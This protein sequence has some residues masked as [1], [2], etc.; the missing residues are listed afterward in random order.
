VLE[1]TKTSRVGWG[2]LFL[3]RPLQGA[4][5]KNLPFDS[6][7]TSFAETEGSYFENSNMITNIN[8]KR[9]EA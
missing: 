9:W 8:A 5:V 1:I 6:E 7:G 3:L 2:A 4:S